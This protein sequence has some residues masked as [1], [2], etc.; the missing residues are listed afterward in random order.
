MKHLAVFFIATFALAGLV[1]AQTSGAFV[2]TGPDGVVARPAGFW[3]NNAAAAKAAMGLAGAITTNQVPGI[4][5]ASPG[6]SR[7]YGT[8]GHGA[9]G[10]FPL[11][12]GGG[13]GGGGGDM[14]AATYDVDGDGIVDEAE[15]ISW[16]AITGKPL[17]FAPAAHTHSADDITAGTV[18]PARLGSGTPG[19]GN[20]LRGDGVWDPIGVADLS[21][22]TETGEA[23]AV[24]ADAAAVRAIAGII[25]GTVPGT[26]A[27]GDHN[28]AGVYLPVTGGALTGPLTISGGTAWHSGNDGAGSLL[29]A[30]LLDGQQGAYFLNRTNQS[31]TQ[32]WSSLHATPTTLSGYGITDAASDSELAA[33]AAAADPH[34][35]YLTPAEGA[36]LYYQTASGIPGA[37]IN[38]GTV[39]P[40]R[41]GSG[42]PSGSTYLRG[43]GAWAAI[44][45]GMGE[46]PVNGTTYGRKDSAWQ[47]LGS[48]ALLSVGTAAGTVAAGDDSRFLSSGQKTD[49]TDGGESS[50]HY[51]AADRNRTNHIGTQPRSSIS[52]FAHASTHQSG[53]SD[54]LSGNL[55]ANARTT[56]RRNSGSDVGARRRINLI[57]G[58]GVSLTIADDPANEELDVVLSSTGGSAPT[59]A[60]LTEGNQTIG[61]NKTFTGSTSFSSL[62]VGDLTVTNNAAALSA[63]GGQPASV[64]LSD[65]ADGEFTG[66]KVGPGI[67]AGNITTGVLAPSRMGTGTPSSA[68]YLRGDGTWQPVSGGSF[69][70]AVDTFLS[71]TNI[72][73]DSFSPVWTNSVPPGETHVLQTDLAYGGQ[74]NRASFLLRAVMANNAGTGVG[75]QN[76]VVSS[77]A[78]ASYGVAHWTN[79]GTNLILLAR[80]PSNE[81][82][83]LHAWG[84]LRRITNAGTYSA[85]PQ[86][87]LF[88]ED[89][90]GVGIPS[91]ALELS[92]GG[93]FNY[94]STSSPLSGSTEHLSIDATAGAAQLLLPLPTAQ[95][96][97][98]FYFAHKRASVTSTGRR[99]AAVM[100][101]SSNVLAYVLT[102]SS[103]GTGMRAQ[104]GNVSNIVA[105]SMNSLSGVWT[106]NWI[107]YSKGTG[108]N[109]YLRWLMAT[110]SAATGTTV[111]VTVTTGT[112]TADAAF[113]ALGHH[114]ALGTTF[115][116]DHAGAMAGTNAITAPPQ[117]P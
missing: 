107:T 83:S 62:S 67:A 102:T 93:T 64:H 104:H 68:N 18:A 44:P 20:Y 25:V 78:S 23:L 49:L 81:P 38:S 4:T 28:H 69:A 75:F 54:A 100:D 111:E 66:S 73:T 87:Y 108:S 59:N 39:A 116:Y 88:W 72:N 97:A 110:N 14:L 91:G 86:G 95:S 31:G 34:P 103:A 8:D 36:S 55:D 50:G 2:T 58:S 6:I 32:P 98:T 37:A 41:L 96:D 13:S 101:A 80:T 33:H 77:Y 48:A 35:G 12:A 70:Y 11:P 71:L 26:Y 43:D 89:F 16:A 109:G 63:L 9:K 113:L 99:M 21:D 15:V 92:S 57:E 61:G 7:Y 42:T 40:E 105:H 19:T 53:G 82:V 90:E 94:E 60:V 10:Y 114:S 117:D 45:G 106:H 3:T 52:D 29:D 65:V 46:A 74:T 17:T 5:A 1:R 22:M 76:S 79:S 27:A 112:A 24:A 47:A 115:V 51:H 56:L 85:P 30:D 84:T